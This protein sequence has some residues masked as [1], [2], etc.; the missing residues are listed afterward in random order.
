MNVL[1][2]FK[3]SKLNPF[4]PLIIEPP[5]DNTAILFLFFIKI[6]I[7]QNFIISDTGFE[8]RIMHRF[9]GFKHTG[10]T[11]GSFTFLRAIARVIFHI[12][13]LLKIEFKIQLTTDIAKAPQNAGQNPATP[14][15]LTIVAANQNNRAFIT[16]INRPRVKMFTG[17]VSRIKIGLIKEFIRPRIKAAINAE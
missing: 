4:V 7:T 11:I 1:K 6:F 9:V 2:F 12:Y 13:Q 17:K 10:C 15:P 3:N 5:S 8:I 14:K 16:N